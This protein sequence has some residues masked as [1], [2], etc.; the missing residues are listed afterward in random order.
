MSDTYA[1]ARIAALRAP[2][3]GPN[4]RAWAEAL[5][6]AQDEETPL[7]RVA[8]VARSPL[9]AP[10]DA[11]VLVLG[12][13]YARPASPRETNSP[14]AYRAR[15]GDSW[16]FWNRV[17]RL[18]GFGDVAAPY[19]VAVGVP[20]ATKAGAALFWLPN[21]TGALDGQRAPF[22]RVWGILAGALAV[23]DVWGSGGPAPGRW[24][25]GGL[26]GVSFDPQAPFSEPNFGVADLDWLRREVRAAKPASAYPVV[27]AASTALDS[28]GWS[29]IWGDGAAWGDGGVWGDPAP[30]SV[31]Y[32]QVGHV[33]GEEKWIG[34]GP[35]LWGTPGDTWA[36]FE[37]PSAGW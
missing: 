2:I 36:N 13:S 23:D 21:I 18:S 15:L 16:G 3:A 11:L 24:G 27:I 22:G 19:V 20:G 14:E 33:W 35:G 12:S 6:T 10:D 8:G 9:K 31:V 32:L 29:A 37:P 25:D 26:W 34:G 28:Q 30:A 4:G 1:A 7:L 5:G 17:Q